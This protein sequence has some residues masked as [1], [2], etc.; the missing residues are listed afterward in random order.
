MIFAALF[1]SGCTGRDNGE[2]AG[3]TPG[4][5]VDNESYA[6]TAGGVRTPAETAAT[7]EA[8]ATP[9]VAGPKIDSVYTDLAPSK[10][11]QLELNEEE[12]G[13]SVQRCKGAFGYDLIVSEGDIRQ[14]IDVVD[15]KGKKHE[16][17]LWNVVSGGFSS[18]GEKAEWRFREE[19]GKKVPFA[20]IV[21]FNASEDP[22]NPGKN[23]SYLTVSK[24]T[25]GEIC[26]T[27]VVKPI[28]NANVK[29]RE[30]AVEAPTKPCLKR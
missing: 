6:G 23:T 13:W 11:K 19:D 21:R 12:G 2:N 27:D 14:T 25:E 3:F 26:V 20:L 15:P 7:P 5:T 4:N 17:N 30:L 28:R 18:V 1:F 22:S 29:A 8:A 16:L 10:C 9:E 24:I